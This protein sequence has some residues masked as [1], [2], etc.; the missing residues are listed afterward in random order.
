MHIGRR[1]PVISTVTRNSHLPTDEGYAVLNTQDMISYTF[2]CRV[3]LES[4]IL[5]IQISSNERPRTS[6]GNET[7]SMIFHIGSVSTYYSMYRNIFMETLLMYCI[8]TYCNFVN[9]L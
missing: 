3:R 9:C 4:L 6:L 8:H 7:V 5:S 1:V 2:S